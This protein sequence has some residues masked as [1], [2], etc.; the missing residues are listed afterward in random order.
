MIKKRSFIPRDKPKCL[1]IAV[2]AWTTLGGVILIM[3]LMKLLSYSV[4]VLAGLVSLLLVPVALVS[5]VV[6]PI[7]WVAYVYRRSRGCYQHLVSKPWDK[8]IW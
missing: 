5:M 7:S 2:A 4:P 8:Q 1:V 6:A 3:I